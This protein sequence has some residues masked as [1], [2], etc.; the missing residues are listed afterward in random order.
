MRYITEFTRRRR[1]LPHWEEP[2][3]TYFVRFRLLHPVVDL[4]RPDVAPLIIE[5]LLFP[6][7]KRY[8][9]YDYTVM[10][11]HG[12]GILKPIVRDGATESLGDIMGSM[13]K[14]TARRINRLPGRR[15]P[16]WQDETYSHIIRDPAEYARWANYILE[17]PH[18]A[19]LVDEPTKWPWW[20]RGSGPL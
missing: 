2:G 10:P 1:R 12:H 15:G 17:N 20:G 8:W 6:D 5:G 14:W 18:V 11:D 4:T 3:A 19:G 13:K 9:L 16:L 7:G